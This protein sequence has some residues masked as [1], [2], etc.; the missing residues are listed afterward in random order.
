MNLHPLASVL[1]ML[2]NFQSILAPA[3]SVRFQVSQMSGRSSRV[4]H[5]RLHTPS[6]VEQ[7]AFTASN[8]FVTA[9]LIVIVA[10][11]VANEALSTM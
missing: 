1:L 9:Q 4:G 3:N 2:R 6:S 10:K 11:A 7:A 5:T 8:L